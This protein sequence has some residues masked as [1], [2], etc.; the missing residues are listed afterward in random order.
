MATVHLGIGSNLGDRAANCLDAVERLVLA[1]LEV[2]KRSGLL[3]TE[4]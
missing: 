1:G 4:P 2:R 3:E